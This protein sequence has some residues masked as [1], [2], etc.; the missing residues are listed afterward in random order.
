MKAFMEQYGMAILYMVIGVAFCGMFW[1]VIEQ[2][3]SY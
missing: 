1:Y 3:S 2:L